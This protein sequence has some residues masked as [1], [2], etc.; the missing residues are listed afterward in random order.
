M[1]IPDPIEVMNHNIESLSW[2]WDVA[3]LDDGNNWCPYCGN[4]FTYE[5]IS[6]DASPDSPV[7]C[8]D[9]LPDDT[10]RAYD[11]F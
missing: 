2:Q 9:C 6:V 7:M 4:A 5:P 10:K 1:R 8:Y 3:Q 11:E